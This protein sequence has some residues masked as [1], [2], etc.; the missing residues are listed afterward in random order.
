ML[1]K[2]LTWL[3]GG[4]IKSVG[5]QL[6]EAYKLKLLAKNDK[7]KLDAEVYIKNLEAKQAILLAE[8]GHWMTR[9]IRPAFAAPFVIYNS[10]ILV[11]DKVLGFGT[12]DALSPE[13][14]ELQM[15]VFGAYF[16]VRPFEK[17]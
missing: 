13:Y 6:N 7:D 2:I 3:S 11:W 5:E 16:L 4:L 9:W 14:W 15:I 8:Q 10:K 12:T 17:K 1:A